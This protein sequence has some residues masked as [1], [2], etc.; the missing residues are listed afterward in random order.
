[1][2]RQWWLSLP[3]TADPRAGHGRDRAGRRAGPFLVHLDQR[4]RLRSPPGQPVQQRAG[5]HSSSRPILGSRLNNGPAAARRARWC[6]RLGRLDT[7]LDRFAAVMDPLRMTSRTWAGC[8]GPV[9][10]GNWWSATSTR[11]MPSGRAGGRAGRRYRGSWPP[12]RPG[13][14]ARAAGGTGPRRRSKP[15]SHDVSRADVI[16]QAQGA[17]AAF[18]GG[19]DV[20][21]QGAGPVGERRVDVVVLVERP[22]QCGPVMPWSR[23]GQGRRSRCRRGR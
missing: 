21:G 3:A 11:S 2:S 7:A 22:C 9:S 23:Y 8:A 4:A 16:D 5:H 19:P 1:M 6:H 12:R 17:Q 14:A 13:R 15:G 18:P 20:L 10:V